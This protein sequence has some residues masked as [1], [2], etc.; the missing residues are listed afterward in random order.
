MLRDKIK[1]GITI[2]LAVSGLLT[3]SGFF[4]DIVRLSLFVKI[5]ITIPF[6][7]ICTLGNIE[8]KSL[9]NLLK[10][11]AKLL[12]KKRVKCICVAILFFMM[13]FLTGD[14]SLQKG[15]PTD[16]TSISIPL[17]TPFAS[18]TPTSAST[19][20]MPDP[21]ITT[22]V[23]P[24]ATPVPQT[25]TPMPATPTPTPS[26]HFSTETIETFDAGYR[27]YGS[28][29]YDRAFPL[30]QK[31]AYDGY[32]KAALYLAYCFRDGKGVGKNSFSAFDWFF[33]A[34]ESGLDMA[35]YNLGYCYYSG[36]G[37][38]VNEDLAFEWFQKSAEQNN[39][40]GLLWTGYCYHKG[41]GVE[42]DYENAYKYYVEARVHGNRD[43]DT[44]I[45]ELNQDWGK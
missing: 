26:P 11:L 23:P 3:L 16:S 36:F 35:Q 9:W 10:I 20:P 18:E 28:K 6:L 7:V 37:V 12:T 32:P 39:K 14:V 31:S 41:I 45:K 1:I 25:P 42:K 24:A 27:Y 43:A 13:F 15:K 8:K 21:T 29:E 38:R 34:A 4:F 30:F 2:A 40:F 33:V 44:R 19:T 17:N 5:L 22:P